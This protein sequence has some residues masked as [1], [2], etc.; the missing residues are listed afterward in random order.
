MCKSVSGLRQGNQANSLG[1][2]PEHLTAVQSL[3]PLSSPYFLHSSNFTE[4]FPRHH[5]D[6]DTAF[7][8]LYILPTTGKKLGLDSL[9]AGESTIGIFR[10]EEQS[11]PLSL[12]LMAT[13]SRGRVGCAEDRCA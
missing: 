7:F 4:L 5:T 2:T 3:F 9:K 11:T 13:I 10:L 6:D 12:G 1:L 8:H